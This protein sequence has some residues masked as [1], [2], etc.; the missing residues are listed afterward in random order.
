MAVLEAYTNTRLPERS[1]VEV[2]RYEAWYQEMFSQ[3][4]GLGGLL[5]GAQYILHPILVV[6]AFRG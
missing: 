5:Q 1:Y 6:R 3:P 2:G 4:L